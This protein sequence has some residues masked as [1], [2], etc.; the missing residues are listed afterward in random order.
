MVE[1]QASFTATINRYIRNDPGYKT[2]LT[3]DLGQTCAVETTCPTSTHGVASLGDGPK[4]N[5]RVLIADGY[6]DKLLLLAGFHILAVR[7]QPRDPRAKHH[8]R[9]LRVGAHDVHPRPS[10]VKMKGYRGVHP[11]R[12][13]SEPGA[14]TAAESSVSGA[15]CPGE[16]P[17]R[18]YSEDSPEVPGE[19][20]LVANPASSAA[21]GLGASRK[22]PGEPPGDG[23]VR[24]RR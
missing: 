6:Y 2:D 11:R 7:L 10:L 22:W 24:V 4:P 18:G 19:M 5:P 12:H 14:L 21:C 16:I 20:G 9:H 8:H 23:L 1:I 3:Y 13:G 17:P 15:V